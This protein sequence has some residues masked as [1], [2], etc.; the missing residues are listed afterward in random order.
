M[1]P[2]ELD[3]QEKHAK[4]TVQLITNK[5]L[6]EHS[7]GKI[8]T[9]GDYLHELGHSDKHIKE[10]LH[11]RDN[12][13]ARP[14]TYKDV[15]SLL[16]DLRISVE[17]EYWLK[18]NPPKFIEEIPSV[19]IHI[20]DSQKLDKEPIPLDKDY[21]L[22]KSPK[23]KATL[24][25]FQKRD[26][27]RLLDGIRVHNYHAQMLVAEAG[28]GKTF[29]IGAVLRRLLDINFHVGKT[30]SPWP[31]IYVTKASVVE[32]TKRVLEKDFSID[33]VREVTVT[34]YDQLR[35]YFGEL[36]VKEQTIVDGGIEYTAWKWNDVLAP[37]IFIFDECQAAKNRTSTQSKIVKAVSRIQNDHTYCIFSSA[38]PFTRVSEAEYFV[39]NGRLDL[40]LI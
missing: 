36:Y 40:T 27:K 16:D 6:A 7:F 21:G 23:E 20:V 12:E 10:V 24:F 25:W 33:L 26:T 11:Y 3:K 29:I 15:K 8:K 32:Q 4:R 22:V 2:T 35:C 18:K 31:Y 28:R 5:V 19:P 13:L 1:K 37:C 39:V 17:T 30:I 34:N 14:L 9:L 38:T